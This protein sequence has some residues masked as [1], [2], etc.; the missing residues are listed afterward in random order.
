MGKPQRDSSATREQGNIPDTAEICPRDAQDVANALINT[1]KGGLYA[2]VKPMFLIDDMANR[3]RIID[4]LDKME[5]NMARGA[6]QNDLAVV[7]FSGH[8]IMV[9]GKFYLVPY[10]V[11]DSTPAARQS[12]LLSATE[13]RDLIARLATHGR[14]LVL[15]D[16]CRSAG[17][18]SGADIRK[19]MAAGNVTVLTS[20]DAP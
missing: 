4:A 18:I 2:N 3:T 1:Q 13:F 19:E 14:V 17:L 12:T 6:G 11:D 16:A 8:G 5:T 9:H 15:L 10:G 7:M 20:S